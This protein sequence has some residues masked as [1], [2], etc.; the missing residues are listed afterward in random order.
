MR[1]FQSMM[2]VEDYE[3]DL[4]RLRK[5]YIDVIRLLAESRKENEDLR[6]ELE[7][8]RCKEKIMREKK[9]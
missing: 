9:C 5:S 8:E 6:T 1:A 3:R 4:F 2:T 7:L